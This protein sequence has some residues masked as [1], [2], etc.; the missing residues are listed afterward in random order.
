ML[1][2]RIYLFSGLLLLTILLLSIAPV[3]FA[4]IAP[5]PSPGPGPGP[6]PET[7]ETTE[8]AGSVRLPGSNI[9]A[10]NINAWETAESIIDKLLGFLGLIAVV[11]I[12]YGGFRW[13]TAGGNEDAVK[14]AKHTLTAGIIGLIIVLA[15]WGIARFVISLMPTRTT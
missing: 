1:K 11:V 6:S 2:K 9:V 10:S 8:T 5:P 3:A 4:Q 15:A 12:L 13:M 7:P 14:K